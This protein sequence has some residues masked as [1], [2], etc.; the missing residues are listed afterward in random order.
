MVQVFYCC[1]KHYWTVESSL[2]I[3]VIFMDDTQKTIVPMIGCPIVKQCLYIYIYGAKQFI[4]LEL[5]WSSVIII[6][7]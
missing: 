4:F 5:I 2:E 1:D 3:F 6:S 7:S